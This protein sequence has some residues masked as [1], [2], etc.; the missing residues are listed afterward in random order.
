[1]RAVLR[2]G[3]PKPLVVVLVKLCLTLLQPWTVAC[4]APLSMGFFSGK[5]TGVG[6][7]F[8]FQWIF[9]TQGAN[10]HL[11]HWQADSLPLSHLESL[12]H[13]K[14]KPLGSPSTLSH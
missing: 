12:W 3:A 2:G 9:P 10:L 8:L 13:A 7:R 1:M 4:Q 11:L 6:C 5:D 14:L